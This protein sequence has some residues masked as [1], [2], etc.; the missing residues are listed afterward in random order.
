MWIVKKGLFCLEDLCGRI[1]STFE[2]IGMEFRAFVCIVS[3]HFVVVLALSR[4][5]DTKQI[6]EKSVR[7]KRLL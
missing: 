4:Y 1:I 5:L 7:L 3:W 6:K 2:I